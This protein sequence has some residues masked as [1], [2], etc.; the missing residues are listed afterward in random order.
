MA[1]LQNRL[2]QALGARY[3]IE[4]ELGQGGMGLVFLA[5]DLKHRRKV[6][7]KVLRPEFAQ[8]L[9]AERFLREIRIA[10]Q[11]S[12]PNILTLIDSGEVDGFM[13][14]VMPYVEGES[15]RDR[16]NREK[17][18]PLDDALEVAREV[19]DALTYAH[20]RG[21]VHRDIKPENILSE[22]GHAVVGDFGIARAI[23]EAGGEQ[24][25][26][27]GLAVG[28][29]AYMSPEQA[30]GAPPVDART[31][32]YSLGC[33]LYEMLVGSPPYVGPTPQA[34]L[35]RKAV[36][37]IP[38]LR[39]VRDTV[40]MA[41]E[42]AI[43]KALAKVPADRFA[44]ARQFAEALSER[45]LRAAVA[46]STLGAGRKR[47]NL[48]ALALAGVLVASGTYALV[49]RNGDGRSGRPTP[50][51]A[52]FRQLTAEPGVEW[53]P[54]LSPDGKWIAYA[55]EGAGNRDIY[56]KSVGGQNPIN[57]TKD[58]PADD[59]QPA[60]SPDGERIAFR[61]SREGGGIFVMGRTG[62]AVKRVT[63]VGFKPA[64]SPDGT[65]LAFTT[66]NVELNP[67]NSEGQ[68]E[69][70][71]ANVTTGAT[72]RLDVVD[73]VLASWSPH[74]HRIAYTRRL[75]QTA[76]RD[77]WTIA[78]AGGEPAPVTADVARDWNPAWSPDGN[79]LYFASDRGGSMNLW[80]IAI[81]EASGKARGDP[82]PITTP[83]TSLGH[84]S[85]SADGRQIAYSSVLVTINIQKMGFDPMAGAARGE[86]EWVTTGTRRWSSPDPSP[87][88]RTVAFYSLVQPEG[89]V[90]VVG[91]DG[92]GL[93]QVTGG[94]ST[95]DRVPRWSPD[96]DWIAFFST[97]SGPLQLWKIRRDGSELTQLTA[98]PTN[99]GV[100]AWSPDGSRMVGSPVDRGRATYA[101]DPQQPWDRQV[102][103]TLSP[104]P[105]ALTPFIANSWSPDGRR[106]A[107]DIEY[108][109][110]GIA[111]Y[112][113]D[114]GTYERLTNFGQW[115]V[116]LP[117]SRRVLFVSGGNGFFLVD[118]ATKR[119]QKI[120]SVTRD[121]LGPPRLSR[122]GRQMYF[123]RRVTEADIWLMTLR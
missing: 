25:T 64:W 38:S 84:I 119:V 118:R 67:Q 40:P 123:S 87:D 2:D 16:L 105:S 122:D 112:T 116:W 117:D 69:L 19:A 12:H 33:V 85:V 75:G 3:R 48:L 41:V 101:F 10:A 89:D 104:A 107:G 98:A 120:F 32:I 102:P 9:G 34:I 39:V 13:Y 14:Y 82:E 50:L 42:R 49:R 94:D 113:F 62:E 57:L 8:S 24:L 71:V 100:A 80:R 30:A 111:I 37:P 11:L 110:A 52:T 109:D 26:Q 28:T 99:I 93:R 17:Q 97:R 15:L 76:V 45:G 20:S 114:A 59:D 91:A 7:L 53:F 1:D 44:T 106:L 90:Y 29:P 47:R 103:Q 31:D 77:V 21:V 35:A 96:G 61:S 121:V 68:S 43:T 27:S 51:H 73:A 63:R 92:T 78:A 95:I 58:S 72:R 83:A 79:Y 74:G 108:K 6:A 23:S 54:S 115:P 5:E 55:G 60:F 36:E 18:L 88:G 86:P 81:D 46:A 66:E 70:W 56:L 4:R 65:H 22:A